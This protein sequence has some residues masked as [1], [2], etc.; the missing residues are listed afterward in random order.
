MIKNITF[1]KEDNRREKAN[2]DNLDDGQVQFRKYEEREK[3]HLG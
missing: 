2:R 3:S 1:K